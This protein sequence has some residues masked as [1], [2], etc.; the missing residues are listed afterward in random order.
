MEKIA[1]YPK[2]YDTHIA[3]VI[4]RYNQARAQ[5]VNSASFLFVTDMHIHMNGRAS[6]PLI[7]QIGDQTDVETV[8]C[9]GDFCW[10]WGSK[11]ECVSQFEDA[12]AY[13][14]PIKDG[15]KLYIARG[16]HDATVR[17]SW[18]DDGGYTMPYDHVQSYFA[19]HNSPVCGAVEGK[20]YFYADNPLSKIRYVILDTSEVHL[21]EDCSWGVKTG[22]QPEQLRWLCDTALRFREGGGW[23]VV[24]MGHI[25]CCEEIPGYSGE[26]EPLAQVLEAFKNKTRCEYGDFSDSEAEMMLYLCGHNHKDRHAVSSGVLH[27][28]TGCDA[29]CKDDGMPRPVGTVDNTL[30]DLFLVDKDK[31]T[32]QIFRVGAGKNRNFDY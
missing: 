16:N 12:F 2:F 3:D 7:R 21:G 30:F 17:N 8:L 4:R 18:E 22:M 15:M 28:S 14:D 6:V 5:I 19:A 9:G 31:K 27:V 13:L 1:E 29:Y 26:L 10:A 25:P 23:S 32:V 20:L 24:V 11:A